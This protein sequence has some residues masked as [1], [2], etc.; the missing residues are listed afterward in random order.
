MV[1]L[2]MQIDFVIMRVFQQYYYHVSS[3]RKIDVVSPECFTLSSGSGCLAVSLKEIP[4][5]HIKNGKECI[6]VCSCSA[7]QPGGCFVVLRP[8]QYMYVHVCSARAH[9]SDS[10]FR[11]KS[12]PSGMTTQIRHCF[13]ST[14]RWWWRWWASAVGIRW[15]AERVHRGGAR[16]LGR[17]YK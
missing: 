16:N 2:S 7:K 1:I 14:Y 12:L 15:C 17:T 11:H 3:W 13:T 8:V 5:I 4:L 6:S 9:L 10:L